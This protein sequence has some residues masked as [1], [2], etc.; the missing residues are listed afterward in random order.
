MFAL[1]KIS[2]SGE[3]EVVKMHMSKDVLQA[4]KEEKET[5][6]QDYLAPY[7]ELIEKV[8]QGD[9]IGAIFKLEA[10]KLKYINQYIIKGLM[11]TD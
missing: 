8:P 3:I 5:S 10:I 9:T 4:I 2:G 1:L 7:R 6:E 11:F